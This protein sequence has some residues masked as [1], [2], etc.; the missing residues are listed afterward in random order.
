ME[1]NLYLEYIKNSYSPINKETNNPNLII[2]QKGGQNIWQPPWQKRDIDGQSANVKLFNIINLLGKS[3]VRLPTEPPRHP[4]QS[5][6][7]M[8]YHGTPT[9]RVKITKIDHT[10]STW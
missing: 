10:K 7:T 2:K 8:K 6:T 9:R 4:Q 1:K 5:K 3:K